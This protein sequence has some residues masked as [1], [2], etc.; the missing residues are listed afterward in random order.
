MVC[1]KWLGV[2]HHSHQQLLAITTLRACLGS[3]GSTLFFSWQVFLILCSGIQVVSVLQPDSSLGWRGPHL[4]LLGLLCS[5]FP[6]APPFPHPTPKQPFHPDRKGKEIFF[7]CP[8]S[9][10]LPFKYPEAALPDFS[11]NVYRSI[12]SRLALGLGALVCCLL[13]YQRSA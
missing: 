6:N 3:P 13:L 10:V 11:S 8:L 1:L 9:T 4:L 7:N 5:V 2:A 12:E